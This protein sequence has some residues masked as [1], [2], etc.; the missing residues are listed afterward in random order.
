MYVHAFMH[1]PMPNDARV[2][3]CAHANVKSHLKHKDH[4]VRHNLSRRKAN[5]TLQIKVDSNAKVS[6]N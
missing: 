3:V 6:V 5:K 2:C 1:E 4:V